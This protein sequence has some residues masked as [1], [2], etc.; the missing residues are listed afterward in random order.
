MGDP[1]WNEHV[2]SKWMRLSDMENSLCGAKHAYK[3]HT[4]G[5]QEC[6]ECQQ[7]HLELLEREFN[8]LSLDAD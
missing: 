6:A 5:H 2:V 7:I 1:N 4:Y 8:T 3:E